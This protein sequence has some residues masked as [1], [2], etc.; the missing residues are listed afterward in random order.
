M[1]LW[2]EIIEGDCLKVMNSIK[3]QSVDLVLCDLPYGMTN[4]RW[5]TLIDLVKLWE[6]YKRII[7]PNGVIALTG[8]HAFTA[9]LIMSNLSWFR[10]KIVWIKSKAG[11]FLNA[12]KQPLR[13][14]E[15]ICIFYDRQPLYLPQKVDGQPYDKGIRKDNKSGSYG[16]FNSFPARSIDGSRWPTDV[17]FFEEEEIK[18]WI[19]TKVA[20]DTD[21]VFH[22]TQKPVDLGRWII[23]T[24]TRPGQVVLDN[25]C[26]SGS[27]LVA[28][29]LEDRHF[30]G[31][32][33]NDRSFHHGKAVD[34]ISI[35]RKRIAEARLQL[36]QSG[37][38]NEEQF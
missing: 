38:F 11:N 16:S 14:H 5:D 12:Q 22:P 31:I 3:D 20:S 13:R 1:E 19:Y 10:Y 2:D 34:Y 33:K 30:I 15:D 26:G 9:R 18:D 4:N 7:K 29:V 24:Y 25:A 27:F 28:A 36:N 37:L 17:Q 35:T 32:D 6:H 21:G 8:Q 23:R